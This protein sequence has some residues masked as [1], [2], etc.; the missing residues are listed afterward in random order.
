MSQKP[1]AGVPVRPASANRAAPKGV[2]AKADPPVAEADVPAPAEPNT[3]EPGEKVGVISSFAPLVKKM[4]PAS[5][6]V[7]GARNLWT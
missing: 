5:A 6:A 1:R 2:V 3:P 4:I 7:A